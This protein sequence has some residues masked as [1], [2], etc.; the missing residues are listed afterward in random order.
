MYDNESVDEDL[1]LAPDTLSI[2]Q[3]FLREKEERDK[4]EQGLLGS[5]KFEENWVS[6]YLIRHCPIF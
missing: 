3:E 5:A 1:Q 2:L 4:Q 6:C